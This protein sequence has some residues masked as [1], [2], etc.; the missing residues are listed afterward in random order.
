MFDGTEKFDGTENLA[1]AQKA[2]P[3]AEGTSLRADRGRVVSGLVRQ[4]TTGSTTNE[5]LVNTGQPFL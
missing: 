3:G 5:R 4:L 1:A 2:G